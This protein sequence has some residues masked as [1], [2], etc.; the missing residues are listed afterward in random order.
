[1]NQS[2]ITWTKQNDSTYIGK[3]SKYPTVEFIIDEFNSGDIFYLSTYVNEPKDDGYYIPFGQF[4]SL[5]NAKNKAESIV[6][7]SEE[8][9]IEK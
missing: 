8:K 5:E 1:M 9:R 3:S 7:K 6:I 4:R 2:K